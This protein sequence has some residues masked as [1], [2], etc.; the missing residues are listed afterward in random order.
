MQW[1][2]WSSLGELVGGGGAGGVGNSAGMP[3]EAAEL[4]RGQ[5]R[6]GSEHGQ[7]NVTVRLLK[8]RLD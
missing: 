6:T 8:R 1:T 5:G 7:L 4:R 2:V 3:K